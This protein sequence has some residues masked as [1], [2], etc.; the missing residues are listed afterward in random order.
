M[1]TRGIPMNRA[2]LTFRVGGE[3]YGLPVGNIIQVLHMIALNEIP[4]SD[5]VGVMTLREQI[6]PVIDLR[7][8]FGISVPA[9]ELDT[10]IICVNTEQRAFGLVVD[11]VDNVAHI[12]ETDVNPYSVDCI[13]GVFRLDGRTVFLINLLEVAAKTEQ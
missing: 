10:P 3:W 7:Q 6:L 9:F 2:F 8:R 4:G 13:E 1:V 5:I 12:A 11:E